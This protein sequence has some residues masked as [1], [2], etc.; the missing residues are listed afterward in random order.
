MKKI[1][2]KYTVGTLSALVATSLIT[3]SVTAE[4]VVNDVPTQE[5]L[6]QN[7]LIMEQELPVQTAAPTTAAPAPTTATPAPTT[8]APAPTTAAPQK[9]TTKYTA[10]EHAFLENYIRELSK[11]LG[12]APVGLT[13][14]EADEI[15]KKRRAGENVQVQ[16]PNTATA[17]T[18]PVKKTT[19]N[20]D[21]DE[22]LDHE[23]YEDK[24]IEKDI[25]SVKFVTFDKK[26]N[27]KKVH[28]FEK[29]DEK[30]SEDK[31]EDKKKPKYSDD[32]AKVGF[33][34][35]TSYAIVELEDGIYGQLV[36]DRKT[37][38]KRITVKYDLL[39]DKMEKGTWEYKDED[40]VEVKKEE[41]T[42]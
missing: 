31:K 1:F 42:R 22:N 9:P 19:S 20:K 24:E 37:G 40:V 23:V 16:K 15:L 2:K 12:G 38:K 30:D 21:K 35:G 11:L 36:I 10:E 29:S 28:A 33:T 17:T 14:G 5:N 4:E 27:K 39:E 3:T 41:E 18:A 13:E 25:Y 26:A 7:G 32:P 8:A 34:P 6:A